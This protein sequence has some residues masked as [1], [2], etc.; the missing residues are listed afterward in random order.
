M[1]QFVQVLSTTLQR[2]SNRTAGRYNVATDR[3][4]NFFGH[5]SDQA[6]VDTNTTGP[7]HRSEKKVQKKM[8]GTD[9]IPK[10]APSK[11]PATFY[12]VRRKYT[13][14]SRVRTILITHL[15]LSI[16]VSVVG[17]PVTGRLVRASAP[18]GLMCLRNPHLCIVVPSDACRR[19]EHEDARN[20]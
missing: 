6:E 1:F 14:C 19:E 20:I 16:S 9:E 3:Q 7:C 2:L 4:T 5:I 11:V 12:D 17:R 8:P 13:S 15:G 18:L 10:V